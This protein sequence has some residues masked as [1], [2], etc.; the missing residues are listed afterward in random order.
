MVLSEMM[1][2]LF[3]MK[4][5]CK[6]GTEMHRI[7]CSTGALIGRPNGR[8]FRLLEN[9]VNDLRCDGYE[10]MMYNT[11][12]DQEKEILGFLRRIK[13]PVFVW[14]CE[15]QIGQDIAS[16]EDE[17]LQKARERFRIN[18]RMAA[19]AGAEKMVMHL[20]DGIISDSRIGNNLQAFSWLREMAEEQGLD[21]MAEN[22]VCNQQDPMIHWQALA[23][24]YSDIHFTFDTK[25]A[26]FHDQMDLIRHPDLRWLWTEKHIRHL[27]INDYTGGYLDWV[28]LRTLPIGKGK[29]DFDAFFTFLEGMQYQGDYTVEA[30]AFDQTGAI[31][32]DM[33]NGSLDWIRTRLQRKG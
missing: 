30:T 25:M 1:Y 11:W 8:N 19:E 4:D 2:L 9:C 15:K 24:M 18:C 12:Y 32:L 17:A 21:L 16:G 22:V 14:H 20:W 27:H 5:E 26:A 29:I 3:S 31:E 7:L 28:N 10:F 13:L 33:L 6:E 23:R